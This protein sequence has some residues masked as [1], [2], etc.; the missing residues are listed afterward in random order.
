MANHILIGVMLMALI[1]ACSLTGPLT[2]DQGTDET[3]SGG[4][5]SQQG[6]IVGEATRTADL[7]SCLTSCESP[8]VSDK[9]SC[10]NG[11]YVAKA[12]ETKDLSYCDQIEQVEDYDT[13]SGCYTSVA[14]AAK[15]PEVC[16][17]L[18]DAEA[19]KSVYDASF[20]D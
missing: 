13:Y 9:T 7:Q 14:I 5:D 8:S 11:C 16:N 19:C 6:Y 17:Y 2:G 20:I 3:G 15:N 1:N 12:V 10:K 18:Y 4:T